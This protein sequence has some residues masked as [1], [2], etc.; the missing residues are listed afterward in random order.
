MALTMFHGNKA[1]GLMGME[2]HIHVY[3]PTHNDIISYNFLREG[4]IFLAIRNGG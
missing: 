3:M 4:K 1:T 2:G